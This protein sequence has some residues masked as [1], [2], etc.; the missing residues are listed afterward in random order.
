MSRADPSGN[1]LPDAT[2]PNDAGPVECLG[3]TF[4]SDDARRDHFLAR[5]KEKLPDLRQRH[6]FP[7]GE[8][9]DILRL[10]DPPYYTACPNPFLVEFVER[11]GKPY[12][13]DEPYHREPF[14]VDVSV[15]KT[16]PLY[17]AHGYHTKVPH[18]A[19][20]PS[21]LHYTKP[22]DIVLDG[23]CG[24]GMTGV[25]AQWCGSAPPDYRIELEQQW[26]KE[27]RQPPQWGARRA[28]LGDLSPAATFIAANYNI[29]FDVDAFADA[30]QKLLDDVEEEIG[31]MYETL[32]TDG[33]TKG[34]IN[35]TV[36]SECFS[37]P[38]CTREIVF[39]DV[40]L[41]P[42]GKTQ[43][44]FLCP[45]CSKVLNKRA[46]NRRYETTPDIATGTPSKKILLKP[47]LIN[48]TIG[49]T[50]YTKTPDQQDRFTLDRISALRLPIEAPDNP[51]P[52][53]R[54]SHGSRLEPKGIT[55]VHHSYL[56]R[57]LHAL[58]VMWRKA[59]QHKDRRIRNV[60]LFLVEQAVLTMSLLNR[61]RANQGS[62]S[63]QVLSGVYYVPSQIAEISPWY[64]FSRKVRTISR[65][66][67]F[68]VISDCVAAS[69]SDGAVSTIPSNSVDYVFV[70]PPFGENIF[71]AD[72]NYMVESW[73]RL[74][75]STQTEAIVDKFKGKGLPEYQRLMELCF[76][77]FYRV[78]KPGRWMTIVFH[79]SKNVIWAAIQEAIFSARFVV[80][81]VRV[82][83]KVQRTYRQITSDAVKRD[84]VI[85]AYKPNGGLE[86]RFEIHAG[87]DEGVWEFIRIHLRQLPVFFSSD[88]E[89]EVVA[90][91]QGNLLYDRMI[92]FHVL[93]G[94]AVPLSAGE[95]YEALAQRY[96][97]R[98]G[99]YFLPEQAVAYDRNRSGKVVRQLDIFVKDE[100]TAIQWLRHQLE[101]KPRTFQDIH[102]T[103]IQ[104]IGGWSKHEEI[105]ELSQ[106]LMENFLQYD[107]TGDVPPQI[108]TYLSTNFKDLRKLAK[109]DPSLQTKAKAR[110][111]VPDPHKAADLEKLRERTLLREFAEYLN[112]DLRRLRVFRLEAIRYGFHRA[113]QERDYATIV[114]VGGKIPG[115]V[116]QE[117]P[118]LL[119]WLDQATVR[120][121]RAR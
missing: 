24:S 60:L 68:R 18:R 110:W 81:D 33:K 114:A 27:G 25:A 22:G 98:D 54:M 56:S 47:V 76:K 90:E 20:V 80:A 39:V 34:Q 7:I 15:G 97:R 116:I 2:A 101:K 53:D 69:T 83:D 112:A 109:D 66:F 6:D 40:A 88:G 111:Y 8:D 77:E 4:E 13:P 99:M 102:P 106:L 57:S 103:Y 64:R 31:W 52:I 50:Q 105:Q 35:Y 10:S 108:H 26:K 61:Y 78:L 42:L 86:A 92:S 19:I 43:D 9:D 95:F 85:S 48:Y 28:I 46:L 29:P 49:T 104:E 14:A 96:P 59:R 115:S 38:Q 65:L 58:S 12:D 84:L 3:M 93:R 120:Q 1:L 67:D 113:W 11:Y 82:L 74:H 21:I 62:Q 87:T 44:S 117:D 118:K 41:G 121:E 36:W 100:N 72:L 32:H 89:L 107:G 75:T 91:R 37:C 30:A 45:S 55:H 119:M 63:N 17:K 51:F 23:F 70:D 94:I 5:L 16:D 73:H 71:Y 79:N